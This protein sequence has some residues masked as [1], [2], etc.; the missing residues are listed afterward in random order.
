MKDVLILTGGQEEHHY[1]A[2]AVR[3]LLEEE[4]GTEIR[5]EV[6]EVGQG[7]IEG[8]LGW[9][10][11][12]MGSGKAKGETFGKW[13]RR[14]GIDVLG[15]SGW[16]QLR[17][18]VALTLEEARPE[19]VVFFHPAVG[20]A[21]QERVHDRSEA[22]FQRVG[23][24][25]EA[26]ELPGWD[27]VTADL[28]WVAD[29]GSAKELREKN[30][31]ARE[32]VAGGWPVRPTFDPGD[33]VKRVGGKKGE[34]FRVLYLI[35][36]RR[37]KAVRTVEKILRSAEVEVTAVVGKEEEL[38][39]DLRK[40]FP[41][42]EGK[43][44]IH[45]WV[46][47][48][49]GMIRAHD[50]VVTKPGTI[51][52]REILATGRP[53]VLVEG[54]KD[55][56]KR[57]GICRLITRLGAGAL[58]DSP[59]EIAAR[60]RQALEGGGVGLREWGRRSRQEAV[61]SLGATERLA[62]RIAQMAQA[63]T[64]IERV[65]ELRLMHHGHL[66]KKGLRMVD[67]HTHT[68]FSDG[69]LTLRELVDFYGRRGFDALA[70]TDHLVD[71]RRL[72]GRLANMSGLVLTSDDLPD[73]F[74]ALAE[75]RNRAWT[76]YRM[77]LFPGLEFNHDGLTAKGSA[78]LLGVDLQKPIDPALSLKEICIEIREQGGLTIAAHPHHMSSAWG[79]DTLYLWERQEEFRPLIDAWE[80]GNR[81]DLFNPVGLKKLPLIAGS[82]FHKPKH[83]TSWK[84]LLWCEKEPEA[85]KE[86]IRRNK[87]VSITLYRDHRFGGESE[88]R[89]EKKGVGRAARESNQ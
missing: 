12:K 59:G 14:A 22:G 80:I 54:G 21:L 57:K 46:K 2:R 73:Y 36:S 31:K 48:L 11:G 8:W 86:C 53:A 6:R 56:E 19:V 38:K 34:P 39:K 28:L 89:D 18:M 27:G 81:D 71:R 61:R 50:L 79:K 82:D 7:G 44:E 23:V 47:N 41:E 67:L 16:P 49:P 66:G 65:P 33:D 17:R 72:L 5:V 78:H 20:L 84:T 3:D 88:E 58:A 76:K 42:S 25:L 24:V 77:I 68:I 85:I 13:I 1:V 64:E 52:V 45:G 32:V 4:S 83:L 10:T 69:R 37:R 26:E 35:N 9:I 62:N 60:I 87:D 51:S 55:S 30:P 74:R 29:E 40:A 70:V 43:L 63:A 75:E 15:S